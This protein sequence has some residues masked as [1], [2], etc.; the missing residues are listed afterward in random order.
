MNRDTAVIQSVTGII[1][2]LVS[3]AFDRR[4]WQRLT[5][6]LPVTLI[7]PKEGSF[8]YPAR[9]RNLSPGGAKLSMLSPV[10]IGAPAVLEHANS[11]LRTLCTVRFC[12]REVDGFSIGLEFEVPLSSNEFETI[13]LILRN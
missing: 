5:V 7:L 4:R 11:R 9:L 13:C 3:L 2:S 1:R 10:K 8:P 6:Y 12:R